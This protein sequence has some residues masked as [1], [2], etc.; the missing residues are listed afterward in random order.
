[1]ETPTVS[2]EIFNVG[3]AERISI[4]DLAER[5]IADDGERV[6]LA[7]FIPYE[8]VYGQGIEDMLHRIP[9]IE[10]IRAAIGWSPTRSL[11]VILQDVI[12]HARRDPSALAESASAS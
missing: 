12:A 9:A 5:V 6:R 1:M 11:D 3:S 7:R 10:K 4:L 2:G 8:R